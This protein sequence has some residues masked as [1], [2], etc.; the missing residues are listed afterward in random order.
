[1]E[2]VRYLRLYNF[3]VPASRSFWILRFLAFIWCMMLLSLP[4]VGVTPKISHFL[5]LCCYTIYSIFFVQ[6]FTGADSNLSVVAMALSGFTDD[7]NTL[8]KEM[9]GSLRTQLKNP[10]LR[11]MFAFLTTDTDNYEEVLVKCD[12]L[13]YYSLPFYLFNHIQPPLTF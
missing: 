2:T 5:G 4:P 8:W 11:A 1:M 13:F 7:K 9:C 6:F 10:Y 3:S 12:I